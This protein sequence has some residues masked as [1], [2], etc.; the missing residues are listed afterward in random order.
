MPAL[1]L[2]TGDSVII[3]S[4]SEISERTSRAIGR[5][6]MAAQGVAA[7]LLELGFKEDDPNTWS[8]Y[9]QL[10]DDAINAMDAYQ[11]ELIIGFLKSWS[12]GELPTRENVVDLPQQLF[13]EL[14]AEC[15]REFTNI[16]DFSP[17]GATDPKAGTDA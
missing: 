6:L 4:R 15:A 11:T 2:S 16:T 7:Q 1:T 10:S 12:R 17:D 13:Q 8:V 3:A 5:A 9:S 14:A